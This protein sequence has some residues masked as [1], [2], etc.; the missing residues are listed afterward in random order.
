MCVDITYR[1]NF[2]Q[3]WN[4]HRC[5]DPS[6]PCLQSDEDHGSQNQ[7][8]CE[9]KSMAYDEEAENGNKNTASLSAKSN[10]RS[11]TPTT[12][13]TFQDPSSPQKQQTTLPSQDQSVDHSVIGC[14]SSISLSA[15][16]HNANVTVVRSLCK[17]SGGNR[18]ERSIYGRICC[19][20]SL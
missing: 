3:R 11:M 13:F 4:H 20:A 16:S 19:Y 5:V 18:L 6:Q 14:A 12:E 10:T 7:K 8:G 9:K 15:P 17:W 1:Y 2:V